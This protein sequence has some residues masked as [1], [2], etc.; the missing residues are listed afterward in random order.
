MPSNL[1]KQNGSPY[2]SAVVQVPKD[3]RHLLGKT[4]FK[5]SL[6]TS[7]KRIAQ[8]KAVEIVDG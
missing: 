6:K 4:A 8:A 3:V 5:K 2:Y 7:D 1:M